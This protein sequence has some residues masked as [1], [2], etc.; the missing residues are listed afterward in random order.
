[1]SLYLSEIISDF[2]KYCNRDW[3]IGYDS[4][5]FWQLTQDSLL[6][7][8]KLKEQLTLSPVIFIAETEPYKFLAFFVAS[9]AAETQVF[10]CNPQWKE[11]EWQQVFELVEPDLILGNDY[12]KSNPKKNAIKENIV[13]VR[14]SHSL[15][16]IPTG[17]SSGKIRFTIH[18]WST[19]TASVTG[20]CD[21]FSTKTVNSFCILP[22]YHVSGLMQFMR[23]FLT[24]GKLAILSYSDLKQGK[25]IKINQQDFFISLVPTQLQFLLQSQPDWLAN[26]QTILLGGAPAWQ[27]LLDEARKYKL[28]LAPTYGMTETA[29]QIVTLKPQDFLIGNNSSGKVL[30][31]AQVTI[32]DENGNLENSNQIGS[33]ALAAESLYLGYYG[34]SVSN[35]HQPLEK[36]ITDDLGFV[37]TQG[38]LHIVGRRSQK[39]ITGGE[40][41]FPAEV[42]AAILAT[43]L[44]KDVC[45][46]GLPDSIW[47]QVVISVYTPVQTNISAVMIQTKIE[48]KLS[49]Y[50]LPKYWI[51]I[52]RL[53]RNERGKIDY[54]KIKST[55][56]ESLPISK[57]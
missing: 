52:D 6:Q 8:L 39:I 13:S 24:S 53:P 30:P 45:V 44:V 29:S 43:E 35:N 51:E 26:F 15:I 9:V 28:P 32:I 1:M 3:L 36:L 37:D 23:S 50:K 27:S 57:I 22:L 5:L 20:F 38:C 21:Y 18:D 34:D 14:K 16:M 11:Q 25:K 4:Q 41:V 48:D 47:G 31:H 33:I 12:L 19:L 17:G 2:K 40:N 49:K 56:I 55:A 42:E 7:L 10:L 46:I 54:Q